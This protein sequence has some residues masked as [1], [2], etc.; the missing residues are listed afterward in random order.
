M[1]PA[2]ELFNVPPLVHS[3]AP[4]MLSPP[5]QPPLGHVSPPGHTHPRAGCTQTALPASRSL[6]KENPW[7]NPTIRGGK[8]GWEPPGLPGAIPGHSHSSRSGTG[9][10]RGCTV[11]TRGFRGHLALFWGCCLVP[12]V[13]CSALLRAPSCRGGGRAAGHSSGDKGHLPAAPEGLAPFAYLLL[14]AVSPRPWGLPLS[15]PGPSRGC[16]VSWSPWSL[17][18]IPARASAMAWRTLS[19]SS[20]TSLGLRPRVST[21][22]RTWMV[23][24]PGR[25]GESQGCV[26]GSHQEPD[27]PPEHFPPQLHLLPS[28]THRHP[29][30]PHP[31]RHPCPLPWEFLSNPH[32]R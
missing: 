13:P 6:W 20:G 19:V 32:P 11:T 5:Q 2:P 29:Q 10:S 7:G 8:H 30:V 14:P 16:S 26:R 17:L 1:T 28:V 25:G 18:A 9:T 31:Q 3:S 4:R 21:L 12:I 24:V 22:G 23:Q 15:S 27:F